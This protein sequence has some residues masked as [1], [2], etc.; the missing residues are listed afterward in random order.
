LAQV[1]HR[2]TLEIS[3]KHV[4][5]ISSH[6]KESYPVEACGVLIGTLA[7]DARTVT[8]VWPAKNQLSSQSSYEI[9]PETLFRAFSHAEQ[10]KLEVIGFYHSHP[11]WSADAS[12]VDKARANYPGL[13]YV[14]YSISRDEIL[15]FYFDG[16]QLTNES[17]VTNVD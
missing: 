8:E 1:P 16:K 3:A 15:S 17:I 4:R 9:D 5:Q 6:S 13:S 2:L 10:N 14:I 12:D 11:F 7:D